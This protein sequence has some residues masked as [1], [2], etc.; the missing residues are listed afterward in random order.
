[1]ETQAQKYFT[2]IDQM[3]ELQ[4]GDLLETAKNK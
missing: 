4:V 1:M 3:S 2:N